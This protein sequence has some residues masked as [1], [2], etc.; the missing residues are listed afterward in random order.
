M[1]KPIIEGRRA[2]DKLLH[3]WVHIQVE[4]TKWERGQY[5]PWQ[6]P[7]EMTRGWHAIRTAAGLPDILPYALRH[8]S[9]VRGI[10]RQLPIRMVAA[11]HNTTVTL[12][13][14]NYTHWITDGLEELAARA[15]VPLLPK[16]AM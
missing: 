3:H 12:I 6:Y 1:L 9:I 8:S 16:R 10:R 4:P 15:V 11:M 2:T 7:S 5:R 14:K 13:E